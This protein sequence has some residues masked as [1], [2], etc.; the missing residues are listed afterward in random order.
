MSK[1]AYAELAGLAVL[2]ARM[3]LKCWFGKWW[4]APACRSNPSDCVAVFTTGSGWG[5]TENV[6]QAAFHNMPMAFGVTLSW[7]A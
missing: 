1:G 6:Q 4:V 2:F 5:L 7:D 3:F